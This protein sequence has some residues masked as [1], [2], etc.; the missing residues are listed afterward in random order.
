MIKALIFDFDGTLSNRSANAYDTYY[1]YYRPLFKDL[2]DLEFEAV[3]QDMM[4]YD[5]NGTF[6]MAT[7]LIPFR[8]KYGAHLPQDFEEVFDRYYHRHMFEY[9]KL[10]KE[11]LE[12][13]DKLKGSYKLAILSNGEP[14]SQHH[15][16]ETVGIEDY[17]D[18]VMVSGDLGIHKP[19]K[20]IF[21]MMA[22]K[23]GVKCEECMMIG[24]VFSSDILGAIRAKMLPVW[25]C[26]DDERKARN[27]KGYRI[28]DL[29][30]LFEIL[31]KENKKD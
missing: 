5:C 27:Y 20:R 30:D 25:M 26:M 7:R 28:R 17:F 4:Y 23:L 24:D 1:D 2:D 11:T 6:D 21:E 3:M 31:D 29:R 8:N 18:E 19:D 9:T 14:F 16:I 13:L 22:E 15:K 12:V 10:K